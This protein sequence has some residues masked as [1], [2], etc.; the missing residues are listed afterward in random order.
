M[1][2]KLIRIL[3]LA[4]IIGV[5]VAIPASTQ[6]LQGTTSSEDDVSLPMVILVNR[7][8]LS[9]DQMQTI[10]DSIDGLLAERDQMQQSVA[11]FKQ[12]M[13]A[14]D[15]TAVELDEQIAEFQSQRRTA[16]Q[17]FQKH[18]T[19]AI[20]EIKATLSMKQGEILTEAFPGWDASPASHGAGSEIRDRVL[21]R[22]GA[23]FP[24]VTEQLRQHLGGQ[25]ADDST[26]SDTTAPTLRQRIMGFGSATD[27]QDTSTPLMGQRMATG[28]RGAAISS[29][30]RS[31]DAGVK[32]APRL[33]WLEQLS[34]ILELKLDSAQPQ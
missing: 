33:A 16:A 19:S 5:L 27:N 1:K 21:G 24:A 8:E 17:T 25:V 2:K 30:G 13:I 9:T 34:Q 3:P 18:V 29:R 31:Q 26:S 11:E 14:F 6:V 32:G 23:E 28:R 7:M 4:L 22:L 10:K 15:G 12:E 20:D